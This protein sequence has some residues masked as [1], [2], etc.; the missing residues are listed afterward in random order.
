M[1]QRYMH[2]KTYNPIYRIRQWYLNKY[3]FGPLNSQINWQHREAQALI[4]QFPEWKVTLLSSLALAQW[5]RLASYFAEF[6]AK[7]GN[8]DKANFFKSRQYSADTGFGL[9]PTEYKLSEARMPSKTTTQEV[10]PKTK[11]K[12]TIHIFEKGEED[13]S[14]HT[15]T[16]DKSMK[17]KQVETFEDMKKKYG[18]SKFFNAIQK[19]V[20]RIEQEIEKTKFLYQ[21]RISKVKQDLVEINEI[22]LDTSSQGAHFDNNLY[23]AVSQLVFHRTFSWFT[24]INYHNF[25]SIIK[26]KTMSYKLSPVKVQQALNKEKEDT[27]CDLK[28][29]VKMREDQFKGELRNDLEKM[30]YKEKE[31]NL[32]QIEQLKKHIFV[33]DNQATINQRGYEQHLLLLRTDLDLQKKEHKQEMKEQSENHKKAMNKQSEK[34]EKEINTLK[35]DINDLKILFQTQNGNPQATGRVGN[36]QHTTYGSSNNRRNDKNDKDDHRSNLNHN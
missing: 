21:D 8:Q 18:K 26:D 32:H 3:Y 31:N 35:Q 24:S 28:N 19:E 16:F 25:E 12:N 33:S 22:L 15:I 20:E 27:L 1:Q 34:H 4:E 9:S 11:E 2:S 7:Q 36:S 6:Y 30:I 17:E 5:N 23:A 13:I 10:T 29:K 14:H